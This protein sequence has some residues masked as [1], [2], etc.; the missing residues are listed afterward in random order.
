MWILCKIFK[1]GSSMVDYQPLLNKIVFI[2]SSFLTVPLFEDSRQVTILLYWTS[3]FST[4]HILF[5]KNINEKR[6]GQ[7]PATN[8]D[9][10][11][12]G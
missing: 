9:P 1:S 6:L 5:T 12:S 3:F 11:T 10:G 4:C 7:N 2:Y 8:I